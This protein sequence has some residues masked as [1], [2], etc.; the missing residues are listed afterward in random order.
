MANAAFYFGLV[1]SLAESERPLWSRLPFAAADANFHE[2]ARHGIAAEVHWPGHDR[3]AAT[4]VVLR[5]LPLAREGL[6]DWGV[7][8]DE[9]DRLLGVVEQ[10]AVRR[11]NGAEWW[12]RRVR[13]RSRDGRRAALRATLLDYR[14]RMHTGQP[15]HTWD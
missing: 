5:L 10:R 8:P 14:D 2:A 4:E 11:T 15:V 12:V 6:L 3:I 1:R 7:E 9:A 13:E